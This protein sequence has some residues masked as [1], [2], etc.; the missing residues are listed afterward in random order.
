MGALANRYVA[1]EFSTDGL[2]EAEYTGNVRL[3]NA[4]KSKALAVEL[5]GQGCE[6]LSQVQTWAELSAGLS[7]QV[8]VRNAARFICEAQRVL[9]AGHSMDANVGDLQMIET[10]AA[11]LEIPE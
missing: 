8:E 2:A 4:C 1:I 6:H 11:D 3:S 10:T 9:L 7:L 5:T